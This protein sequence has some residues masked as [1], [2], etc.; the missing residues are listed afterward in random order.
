MTAPV[1]WR[2]E[3]RLVTRS[4]LHIG[5]GETTERKGL[6]V[7]ERD[8]SKRLA[9]VSAV[10]VDHEGR[11][12]LPGSAVKGALRSWIRE[13]FADSK[14]MVRALFGDEDLR[15]LEERRKD[16]EQSVG[17]K[18]EFW[19]APIA[20][21][22]APSHPPPHWDAKRAT[23]VRAFV[24]LDRRAK[25]VAGERL[26]HE[27]F[28]PS[29]VAFELVITGQGLS[30]DELALLLAAL[31]HGF[32]KD[33]PEPL[34]LGAGTAN[35]DGRFTFELTALRR[36]EEKDFA[37][38]LAQAG[39]AGYEGFPA[40]VDFETR[41]A[42]ARTR[43]T[44]R[45]RDRLSLGLELTF[46]SPFAVGS[47]LR[48]D[49]TEGEG[50]QGARLPALDELGRPVLPGSSLRGALR[51]QAEKI[52]RTVGIRACD[53]GDARACKPIQERK[54][55]GKLCPA[56]RLFGAPGW[57]TAVNVTDFRATGRAPVPHEQEH[58]A[59]DRFT[60]GVAGPRKFT[61]QSFRD[62]TLAGRVTLDRERTRDLP[63]AAGLLALAV[64]DL[65]EGDV[66]L[67]HG[68]ARGFGAVQARVTDPPAGLAALEADRAAFQAALAALRKD[69]GD[70]A[71]T[72]HW[73]ALPSVAAPPP[74]PPAKRPK[75]GDDEFHNPY[76]F[77]PLPKTQGGDPEAL[78]VAKFT[79]GESGAVTH[80]HYVPG[81]FSGRITFQVR[82][83]TPTVLG[84][85]Q[86]RPDDQSPATIYPFELDGEPA[87]PGS[88]LR[89]LLSSLV[90]AVTGSALRV[91]E[92]TG[93]SVRCEMGENLPVLGRLVA[94]E[95]G[96]LKL[97][98]LVLPHLQ[99]EPLS[100][101]WH[102]LFPH[103][104]R[105]KSYVDGWVK[106]GKGVRLKS[107]SFIARRAPRSASSAHEETWFLRL[108]E[109]PR[110][111]EGKE[112]PIVLD[113]PHAKNGWLLGQDALNDEE[114]ITA[115]E[116]AKKPPEI[117]SEYV[118][119][120]LRVLDIAGREAEI[121]TGRKHE[122]FIPTPPLPPGAKPVL[123]DIKEPLAEFHR[124]AAE[125]AAA[126]AY[127]PFG[128]KG[129]PRVDG[130][131]VLLR[132]GD[133]VWFDVDGAGQVKRL[134]L[135]SIW[136]Q[137]KGKAFTYFA[138]RPDLRPFHPD[139]TTID[140]AERLFGF[141][142]EQ[143][144]PERPARAL[145]SRLRVANG[146]LNAEASGTAEPYVCPEPR[147]LAILGS[148]KPPAPALYF[149]QASGKA[150]RK[151]ELKA[152][153]HKPQGRKFFLHQRIAERQ[154]E[155]WWHRGAP[156]P[157]KDKLRVQVR[158]LR[159]GLVFESHLD[160]D[161]LTERE[162][163]LL[164]YALRPTP[165]FRHKLGLGKPLGLGTVEITPLRLETVDR[166]Q[167]YQ[168]D[169]LAAPRH[170]PTVVDLDDLRGRL[171]AE[172]APELRDALELL[173][174]PAAVVAPVHYPQNLDQEIPDESY[175][176]FVRNEDHRET[177]P[178]ALAPV[179]ADSVRKG[180]LPT[181]EKRLPH[182]AGPPGRPAG[183]RPPTPAP[184]KSS[185]FGTME[186]A[187]RK[188]LNLG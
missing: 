45:T 170:S 152:G 112:P 114:P 42:A 151:R 164:A 176:W 14:A 124:L 109:L 126:E 71:A 143:V 38:W 39:N 82:T 169:E 111:G 27:E 57:G 59:I 78:P 18:A 81:T 6:E 103:G 94:D 23:G 175:H 107:G 11:A 138:D 7:E 186:A 131:D 33:A 87:I 16:D 97:E 40:V 142:E 128:L 104:P 15:K 49:S 10:A 156:D 108:G 60:G 163:A 161:N 166:R 88:S 153:T 118:P 62:V 2:L 91:L 90:E 119:G 185:G 159:A 122:I 13:Q 67:G 129:A 51:G 70:P 144:P 99:K 188:K 76:H 183:E 137:G 31:E 149:R 84:A 171:R 101:M 44:P 50:R 5:S 32:A 98:P 146:R 106:D 160:F 172:L 46:D 17:G 3:G 157:T 24:T 61:S 47:A 53:P 72:A 86:H 162:L 48:E 55:V 145:A 147:L 52:L 139:R 127:L 30:D 187:F 154:A 93:Y 1:R 20:G 83:E 168:E 133:L 65:T 56:C 150:V 73:K 96:K 116:L 19:D 22:V 64:R 136:R 54:E 28:V 100:P 41:R 8:K 121:P 117:Q 74:A 134:A 178:Q 92:D 79:Q 26:F 130:K 115:A 110:W 85:S 35:G 80:D 43:W 181:L 155:T 125:R 4:P 12:Y 173:G 148:P 158:P 132:A 25:T 113:R 29:G 135:S 9:E 177:H 167:R 102:R 141:V 34:A 120:I 77:V 37:A 123:L 68:A 174:D 140:A 184:T 69:F 66:P 105:L 36:L 182:G 95:A 58:L 63:W 89:G 165:A 179:S 75:P 21:P 180:A